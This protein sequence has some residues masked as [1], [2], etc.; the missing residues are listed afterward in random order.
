[1]RGSERGS[2]REWG[3]QNISTTMY[4]QSKHLIKRTE[5]YPTQAEQKNQE[6]NKKENQTDC[7]LTTS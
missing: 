4:E 5:L 1:M 6:S 2:E 3:D 7:L